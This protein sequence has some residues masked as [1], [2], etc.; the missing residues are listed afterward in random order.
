[1]SSFHRSHILLNAFSK[2]LADRLA[3]HKMKIQLATAVLNAMQLDYR[4]LKGTP[5]PYLH[6]R[7]HQTL[8]SL[9]APHC[10]RC[11]RLNEKGND[12]LA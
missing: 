3:S 7:L 2:R 5:L 8:P 6:A 12:R 9:A 11:F 10:G 1:M 4:G